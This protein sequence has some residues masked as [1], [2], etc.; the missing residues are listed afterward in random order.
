MVDQ[1]S[2]EDVS[3][4]IDKTT[5]VG[6]V[7]SVLT[8]DAQGP[9]KKALQD[10][11][12]DFV[13]RIT[14]EKGVLHCMGEIQE[15]VETGDEKMPFSTYVD[16]K[17]LTQ[18]FIA[19]HALALIYGPL[20]VEILKPKEIKL[21]MHEAQGIL[22]DASQSSQDFVKY[23]MENAAPA[24]EK[25]KFAA[26]MKQRTELGAKLRQREEEKKEKK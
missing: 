20:S 18:D 4:L 15:V 17:V 23:I 11:L 6:A 2:E 1:Y 14:K 25:A 3:E 10:S 21:S 13:S 8:F 5:K 7:L 22:L 19:L 16:V 26:R 12:V 24:E 9:D